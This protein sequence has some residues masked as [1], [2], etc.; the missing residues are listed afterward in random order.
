M[1]YEEQTLR[2]AH[3]HTSKHRAQVKAVQCGCF[4]CL[5]MFHGASV[6]QWV[7]DGQTALCPSCGIDTVLPLSEEVPADKLEFLKA[8]KALWMNRA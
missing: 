5:S 8:M 4:D 6:T 2:N 1:P 3:K 7:D